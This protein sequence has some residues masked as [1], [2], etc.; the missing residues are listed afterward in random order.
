M[1]ATEAEEFGEIPCDYTPC[2]LP[3]RAA[4]ENVLLPAGE[5]KFI[6]QMTTSSTVELFL[7]Q[8]VPILKIRKLNL[9]PG[10]IINLELN[11]DLPWYA[12]VVDELSLLGSTSQ[13]ELTF[14]WNK[15]TINDV[16]DGLK[17]KQ[18]KKGPPG[19][20]RG[21]MGFPG[22]TGGKG[23]TRHSPSLF[24][25]IR[26]LKANQLDLEAT[27][28]HFDM[29]GLPGGEGGQ[30]GEGGNGTKGKRGR[31]GRI[32]TPPFTACSPGK[33]GG[34]GGAPGLGGRG[35]DGGCGGAG[36]EIYL[37][38]GQESLRNIFE[39]SKFDIAGGP[40]PIGRDGGP[41]FGG[42][43]GIAGQPG[44][45]GKGGRRAGDCSSGARGEPGLPTPGT[46]DWQRWNRKRG[47]PGS[48]GVDGDYFIDPLEAGSRYEIVF[49]DLMI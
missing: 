17:G 11:N 31:H 9:N 19:K 10:T 25:F 48:R 22:E 44:P 2:D 40:G 32:G 4:V 26:S 1:R 24:V 47:L 8:K 13:Y 23:G 5:E 16:L 6:E 46:R 41:G 45:G 49:M 43:P 38:C 15:H 36:P 18:G 42:I 35:G 27:S 7:D 3:P 12:L 39:R 29:Q 34:R 28:F 21:Q 30:G 20:A 14:R 33:R 37:Y